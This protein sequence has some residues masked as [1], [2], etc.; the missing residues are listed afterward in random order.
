MKHTD[1]SVLFANVLIEC[2]PLVLKRQR[3]SLGFSNDRVLNFS[4]DVSPQIKE[5]ESYGVRQI[6]NHN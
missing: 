5:D 6:G 1:W 4:R 3:P 2:S